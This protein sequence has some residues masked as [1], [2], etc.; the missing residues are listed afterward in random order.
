MTKSLG[1]VRFWMMREEQSKISV[2]WAL[3]LELW[4]QMENRA[5]AMLFPPSQPGEQRMATQCQQG[6]CVCVYMYKYIWIVCVHICLFI[7]FPHMDELEASASLRSKQ[8]VSWSESCSQPF[9]CHPHLSV[10]LQERFLLPSVISVYRDQ[11]EGLSFSTIQIKICCCCARNCKLCLLQV[12][13]SSNNF[14][15]F[16]QFLIPHKSENVAAAFNPHWR[17]SCLPS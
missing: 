12:S 1:Y 8:A 3:G 2:P 15:F 9:S 10:C 6:D 11:R 13:Y 5:S 4:E 17:N 16:W 14:H 7:V